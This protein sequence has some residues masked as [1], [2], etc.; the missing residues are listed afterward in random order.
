MTLQK[1]ISLNSADKEIPWKEKM[2]SCFCRENI[3]IYTRARQF[4]VNVNCVHLKFLRL[5]IRN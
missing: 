3:N 2:P 5:F 1:I 4:N